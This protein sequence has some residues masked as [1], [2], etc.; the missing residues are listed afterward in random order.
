MHLKT[1]LENILNIKTLNNQFNA[2]NFSAQDSKPQSVHNFFSTKS[3][4][5]HNLDT[6]RL[7]HQH[8]AYHLY[9]LPSPTTP[10]FE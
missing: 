4:T 5:P 2:L 1:I 8:S 6:A 7:I 10:E 9:R 3:S